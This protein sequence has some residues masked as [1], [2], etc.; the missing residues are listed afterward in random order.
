MLPYGWHMVRCMRAVACQWTYVGDL[1]CMVAH[2]VA[3]TGFY[4]WVASLAY[5]CTPR[6]ALMG[7]LVL[8]VLLVVPCL[9]CGLLQAYHR[10]Q[11]GMSVSI[12]RCALCSSM[13]L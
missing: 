8:G 3:C 9:R 1:L 2:M 4:V 10:S 6:V 7:L 11:R 13:P 12:G 5:N